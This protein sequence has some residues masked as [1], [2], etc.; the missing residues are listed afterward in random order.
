MLKQITLGVLAPLTL[1]AFITFKPKQPL[2]PLLPPLPSISQPKTL[3][4]TLL[5]READRHGLPRKLVHAIATVESNK[6]P[7]AK[8][9]CGAIG[10]MQI[11]PY[12]YKTCGLR[13]SADLWD[14]ENNIVCGAYIFSLPNTKVYTS[15]SYCEL[16][17]I[18]NAGFKGLKNL[19]TETKNYL[20]RIIVR[21]QLDF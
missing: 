15:Y 1:T 10:I 5:D 14:I 17:I 13:S 6:N 7:K 8:S 4:D 16:L 11:M 21:T 9:H 2:L 19:P 20:K 12:H 3:I 18:Y